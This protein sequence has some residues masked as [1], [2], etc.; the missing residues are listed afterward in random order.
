L[1]QKTVTGLGNSVIPTYLQNEPGIALS[2]YGDA[3]W[4]KLVKQGKYGARRFDDA[5]VEALAEAITRH[6]DSEQPLEWVTAVPSLREPLLVPEFAQRLAA[7]LE[8]PYRDAIE[9]VADAAAQKSM[10]NSEQQ[11]RNVIGA[12]RIRQDRVSGGAV[13]L[14]DDFV[15]SGWTLTICGLLLREGGSGPVVPATLA[16]MVGASD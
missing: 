14:V 6:R 7:R 10:Q 16:C 13:L 1:L 4:G 9:R 8:L 15:D 12:F 11:V 5:L 2:I 3:G